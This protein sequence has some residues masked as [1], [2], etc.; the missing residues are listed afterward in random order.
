MKG[1]LDGPV[2]VANDLEKSRLYTVLNLP[3]DD[4]LLCPL[5]VDL[6]IQNKKMSLKVD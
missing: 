2:I 1:N 6:W 5:K 3:E 4:D